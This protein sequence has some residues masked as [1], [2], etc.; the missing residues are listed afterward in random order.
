MAQVSF[1]D[2]DYHI[3]LDPNKPG[4]QTPHKVI[5]S[6]GLRLKKRVR[7]NWKVM[8]SYQTYRPTA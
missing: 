5:L 6:V 7:F 3:E 8:H 2:F 4:V 1:K